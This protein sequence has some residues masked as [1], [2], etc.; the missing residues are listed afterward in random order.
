MKKII[1]IFICISLCFLLISCENT[2][3][4]NADISSENEFNSCVEVTFLCFDSVSHLKYKLLNNEIDVQELIKHNYSNNTVLPN[5]DELV[6]FSYPKDVEELG[7]YL[8]DY[9]EYEMRFVTKNELLNEISLRYKQD[10]QSY[11]E[12]IQSYE[13]SIPQEKRD[14]FLCYRFTSD[15]TYYTVIEREYNVG[16]FRRKVFCHNFVNNVYYSIEFGD[17]FPTREEAETFIKGFQPIEVTEFDGFDYYAESLDSQCGEV[18]GNGIKIEDIQKLKKEM[19]IMNIIP[20][21]GKPQRIVDNSE[22]NVILAEWDTETGEVFHAKLTGIK[23]KCYGYSL[24]CLD[25]FD[26]F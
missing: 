17:K 5:P 15:T 4:D 14:S 16:C 2:E 3:K 19:S 7:V 11:E 18:I 1:A 24:F 21:L 26:E 6:D 9:C 20:L 22:E 12:W 10:I 13:K 8:R 25:S 23:S